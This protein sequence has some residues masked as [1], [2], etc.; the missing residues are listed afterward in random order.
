M[1]ALNNS[2]ARSYDRE[3][4]GIPRLIAYHIARLVTTLD[5]HSVV[6]DNGCGPALVTSALLSVH[7]SKNFRVE[8]TDLSAAMIEATDEIIEANGWKN[9]T[10]TIQDSTKLSFEDNK[11]THSFINFLVPIRPEEF[12]EIYR[13]LKP[14]GEAIYTMWKEHGFC[15]VMDRCTALVLPDSPQAKGFRS[16]V[17]DRDNIKQRFLDGGFRGEDVKIDSHKEHLN[18]TDLDDLMALATGPFG[19]FLTK[20]WK[21]GDLQRLPQ[22][23]DQALTAEERERKSLDMV[24]WVVI[25]KKA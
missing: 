25:A 2:L 1:E 8:A 18:F 21:E 5:E 4:R 13:T 11:F 3:N 23:V 9:V 24:A 10:A 6:H 12:G 17:V 7:G 15:A 16:I 20:D 22:L 14:S 19:K